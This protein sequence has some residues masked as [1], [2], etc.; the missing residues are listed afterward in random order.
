MVA[1]FHVVFFFNLKDG[2]E[3]KAAFFLLREREREREEKQGEFG[4]FFESIDV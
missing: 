2:P 3:G 1:N 4:P